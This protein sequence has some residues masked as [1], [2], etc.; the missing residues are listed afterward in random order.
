VRSLSRAFWK[1]ALLIVL[2][3][4]IHITCAGLR[5]TWEAVLMDPTLVG[6]FV[7]ALVGGLLTI[8]GSVATTLISGKRLRTNQHREAHL[9]SGAEALNALQHLNRQL[10]NVAREPEADKPNAGNEFWRDLH[11]AVTRWNSARYVAA[12]YCSQEELDLLGEIDAETDK[13]LELAMSKSWRSREFRPHRQ[14]L[15]V[16]AASYLRAVRTASGQ[17]AVAI[18]SLWAWD[19]N[20]PPAYLPPSHEL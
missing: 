17:P 12:L 5:P 13:L 11:M 10:I 8:T 3:N 18:P 16:L 2:S 4:L 7:G 6:A 19:S 9:A 20:P 14:H 1:V 15:G